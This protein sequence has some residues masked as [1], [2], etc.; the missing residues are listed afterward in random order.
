MG[1]FRNGSKRTNSAQK[2]ALLKPITLRLGADMALRKTFDVIQEF[3]FDVIRNRSDFHEIYT[4]KGEIEYTLSFIEDFGKTHLTILAFSEKK[5]L[6]IKKSL[7]ELM[8][9]LRNK[10]ETYI[11]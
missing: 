3:G 8:A 4:K 10:L 7:K 1:L 2:D 6:K 9:F 5:P 11:E